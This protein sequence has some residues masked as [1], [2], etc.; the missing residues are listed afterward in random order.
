MCCGAQQN[1]CRRSPEL[2]ALG[3][4]LWEL[5]GLSIIGGANHCGH[6]W[7]WGWPTAWLATRPYFMQWL[8]IHWWIPS[9]LATRPRGCWGWYPP[10]D[11]WGQA[12][13]LRVTS[14]KWCLPAPMSSWYNE[15][16]KMA[17]ASIYVP[18][19]SPSYFLHLQEFLQEQVCLTQAPFKL[20]PLHWDSVYEIFCVPL[21]TKSLL[22]TSLWVS[23]T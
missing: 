22:S 12:L 1:T 23:H 10:T 13:G 9:W 6:A 14:P 4:P 3:C 21:R 19:G 11:G 20:L 8:L 17:T 18:R 5:L 2:Y 7:R 15:L 16:P